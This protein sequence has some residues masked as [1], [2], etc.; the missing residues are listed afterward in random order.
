MLTMPVTYSVTCNDTLLGDVLPLFQ[1][2]KP[3]HCEFWCQ[4]LNDSYKVT[5][6]TGLFL[7]RIY[8][9]GW[10]DLEAINFELQALL[11]LKNNGAD[12]AYPIA[13]KEGGYVVNIAAPEGQR[14][15]IL[16]SYVVGS[17]LDFSE[18]QSAQL[19]GQHMARIHQCSEQFNSNHHRFEFNVAHLINEPMC[20]IKP[21]LRHRI[22]DWTFLENKAQALAIELQQALDRSKDIGLCHGDMAGGNA[23]YDGIKLFSFD[24]DCCAVGLRVYDLAI[25]KWSLKQDNKD[26]AIWQRFL[27]SYQQ[28]RPLTDSDL[29][30]IDSLVAIRHIWLMGLHIDVAVAKGWLNDHYFD[31]KIAF[32][33]NK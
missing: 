22:N 5:T 4:G 12:I 27:H 18:P 17:E 15:I 8:R 10:R 25:F 29:K 13:T 26:N 21:F 9:Y 1:I 24:F 23:H 11:H 2:E 6:E 31:Q 16:T 33:R 20:R 28:H 32:L 7:L 14:Y 3:V 19:Y 30:L